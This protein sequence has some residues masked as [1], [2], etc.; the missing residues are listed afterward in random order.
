[1]FPT[2]CGESDDMTETSTPNFKQKV[3]VA[4]VRF[5][6]IYELHAMLAQFHTEHALL[7]VK[8]NVRI[9]VAWSPQRYVG[10]NGSGARR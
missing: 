10:P 7:N 1:M 8:G 9:I 2:I 3:R 6:R 5:L 4:A